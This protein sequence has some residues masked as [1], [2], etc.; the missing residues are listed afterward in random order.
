MD[1]LAYIT[2]MIPNEVKERDIIKALKKIDR[3]GY[4]KS[5]ESEQYDLIFDRKPYPAKVVISYANISANGKEL[6][7]KDFSGGTES[8][9]FLISL[10]FP[11]SVKKSPDHDDCFTSD[12]LRFLERYA[13]QPYDSANRIHRNAGAFISDTLWEKTLYWATAIAEQLPLD[14]QGRRQWN[15]RGGG[16]T[17]Q[18]FKDY[19]WYKLYPRE[20]NHPKIYYTVGVDGYKKLIIKI[21]CQHTG[22]DTLPPEQVT[23]VQD[24]LRTHDL[25]WVVFNEEDLPGLTW[26][27]LIDQSVEFITRTLPVYK[28]IVSLIAGDIP[29]K[30]VRI[31]WNDNDW[32]CPSGQPG[33]SRTSSSSVPH[34][35]ER[36]HGFGPEEWLLDL[37]KTIG[38]HHY[39]RLEP[40][41]TPLNS[42]VG[43]TYH[44]TLFAFNADDSKW[45]WIG[46]IEHAEV[47]TPEESAGIAAEYKSKGWF[48]QQVG[49]LEFFPDVD[50][51]FYA[52]IPDSDLFNVRF[53]P[54][55]FQSYD[56]LP[57]AASEQPPSTHYN[58][59]DRKQPPEFLIHPL[60]APEEAD[61]NGLDL[62]PP[63]WRSGKKKIIRR[64]LESYK[65]LENVHRE[66]QEGILDV[67]KE[68]YPHI[69]FLPE[70]RKM[71]D[72]SRIDI[73]GKKADGK[74]IFYE[75]KTYPSVMQSIRVAVGQLL[76][77]AFY[78]RQVLSTEYFIVTQWQANATELDYLRHLSAQVGCT[79]GYI[80]FNRQKKCIVP[81]ID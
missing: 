11:I 35:Q 54:E 44:L 53:R 27:N 76:E 72:H 25:E 64:R 78:P 17:G 65:E 52:T 48:A 51:A 77:Y 41:H 46:R 55:D 6:S 36:D 71:I 73:V 61:L 39:A 37:D 12:E 2:A 38:D 24:Y 62:T 63:D 40:L 13:G 7:S 29:E 43:K 56:C 58:L 69:E 59:P 26:Q 1:R 31:C 50:A 22:D 4:S 20:I 70:R 79:F 80:H 15:Q 49:Q 81:N 47:I 14:V 9:H 28:A 10:G 33:K 18:S 8:N 68:E 32:Q 30:C 21:D 19:T 74:C 23:I 5:R 60:P 3:D 75:I 67:L 66:I 45:Y 16:K 42:H 57:F 34:I